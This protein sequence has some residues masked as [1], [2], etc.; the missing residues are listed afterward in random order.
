MERGADAPAGDVTKTSPSKGGARGG[1][2][3][4]GGHSESPPLARRSPSTNDGE[5]RRAPSPPVPRTSPSDMYLPERENPSHATEETSSSSSRTIVADSPAASPSF[6]SRTSAN[7]G[8][9]KTPTLNLDAVIETEAPSDSTKDPSRKAS[10]LRSRRR[11]HADPQFLR[12]ADAP[13]VS[14]PGFGL[15]LRPPARRAVRARLREGRRVGWP[16]VCVEQRTAVVATT[17]ATMPMAAA[18]IALFFPL[19]GVLLSLGYLLSGRRR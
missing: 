18:I 3:V 4:P 10:V 8:R 5:A 17:I 1:G 6:S 7:A 16:A 2:R 19:H 11:G 13:S 14:S 12:T 15:R 9:P